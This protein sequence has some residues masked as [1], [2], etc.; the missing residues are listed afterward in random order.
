MAQGSPFGHAIC[1][2]LIKNWMNRRPEL[3]SSQ[4]E[5]GS[6]LTVILQTELNTSSLL[7]IKSSLQMHQVGWTKYLTLHHRLFMKSSAHNVQHTNN[8]KWQYIVELFDKEWIWS[9]YGE[10]TQD[11]RTEHYQQAGLERALHKSIV[12]DILSIWPF[13]RFHLIHKTTTSFCVLIYVL[14]WACHPNAV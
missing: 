5:W 9:S 13:V 3:F 11:K 6:V 8:Q 10:V 7:N 12:F 4:W 14:L 1:S 2:I